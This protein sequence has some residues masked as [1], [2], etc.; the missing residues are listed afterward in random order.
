LGQIGLL[1]HATL[2]P[3]DVVRWLRLRFVLG[4][5]SLINNW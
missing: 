3:Q 4:S 5:R 1:K 2:N